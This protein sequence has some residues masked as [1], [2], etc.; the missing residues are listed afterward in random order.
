MCNLLHMG[1]RRSTPR[2]R[3]TFDLPLRQVELLRMLA[4]KHGLT[5]SGVVSTAITQ[6]AQRDEEL[7]KK[8][9]V[10]DAP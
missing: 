8:T 3:K 9:F 10:T 7:S 1:N 4:E 6:M 2:A 5:E